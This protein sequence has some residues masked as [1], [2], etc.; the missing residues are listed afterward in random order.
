VI[1]AVEPTPMID[2]SATTVTMSLI[3]IRPLT[4]IV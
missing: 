4:R 2:L 3:V 1:S